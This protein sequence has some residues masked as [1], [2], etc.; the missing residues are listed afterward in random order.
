M[1]KICF[2]YQKNDLQRIETIVHQLQREGYLS[3]VAE[4]QSK[5]LTIDLN[6]ADCCIMV[7]SLSSSNS[8]HLLEK[9]RQAQKHHKLI[10]VM[11]D[12]LLKAQIPD[13]LK[14][15]NPIYL[16]NW[17]GDV[18]NPE[19]QKLISQIQTFLTP[20]WVQGLVSEKDQALS[21]EL[22]RFN[23]IKCECDDLKTR[24]EK[25]IEA[26]NLFRQNRAGIFAELDQSKK[27]IQHLQSKLQADNSPPETDPGP[28]RP[29]G[30]LMSAP[31]LL[32]CMMGLAAALGGSAVYMTKVLPAEEASRNAGYKIQKLETELQASGRETVTLKTSISK[33][34]QDFKVAQQ[35]TAAA[36]KTQQKLKAD[37]AESQKQLTRT[38]L[39]IK[40]ARE[41]IINQQNQLRGQ[42][43]KINQLNTRQKRLEKQFETSRA[44]TRDVQAKL[45]AQIRKQKKTEAE[46]SI[47]EAQLKQ[48]Q[49][50]LKQA[51]KQYAETLKELNETKTNLTSP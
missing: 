36:I 26:H 22:E 17:K 23:H 11:L 50:Q 4:G 24:L 41:D 10:H 48:K 1:G 40:Q 33:Q 47:T 15:D 30:H 28:G 19:W 16:P 20:K 35:K 14:A 51:L 32:F 18:K 42:Q 25:E 21:R 39:E 49:A 34:Q 43:G 6:T 44:K 5:P 27:T 45:D 37:L 12:K 7:W 9:A 3:N 46:L 2:F 29:S 38:R 13:D 8:V 31:L